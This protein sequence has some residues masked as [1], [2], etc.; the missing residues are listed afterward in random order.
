MLAQWWATVC[1]AGLPANTI[2]YN[3]LGLMLGQR[4]IRWSNIKPTLFA[5]FVLAGTIETTPCRRP[6][7]A[8]KYDNRYEAFNCIFW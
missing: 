8:G 1:D 4:R 3:N 6:A 5:C 2:H 7:F